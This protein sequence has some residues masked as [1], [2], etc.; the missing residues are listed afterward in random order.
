[1]EDPQVA[2]TNQLPRTMGDV[3]VGRGAPMHQRLLGERIA[4]VGGAITVTMTAKQAADAF[5]TL[6]KVYGESTD[7]VLRAGLRSTLE[8]VSEAYRLHTY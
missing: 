1:M 3:E 5:C 7:L 4:Q 2:T 8:A 6:A